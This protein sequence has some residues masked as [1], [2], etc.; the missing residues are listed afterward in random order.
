MST[1]TQMYRE[2]PF[3]RFSPWE[4]RA[5]LPDGAFLGQVLE[6][7]TMDN[8]AY[9]VMRNGST[10]IGDEPTIMEMR[11]TEVTD[12]PISGNSNIELPYDEGSDF[13]QIRSDSG[14]FTENQFTNGLLYKAAGDSHTFGQ[15]SLVIYNKPSTPF[16]SS[17]N[18]E[19]S[20]NIDPPLLSDWVGDPSG[21][22]VMHPLNG[23]TA[24]TRRHG[25]VCG[26]TVCAVPA[27][28]YFLGL[29]RGS[30][31]LET[32]DITQPI[33]A[34]TKSHRTAGRVRKA[35]A[36]E[37]VIAHYEG[38]STAEN[39]DAGNYSPFYINLLEGL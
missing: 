35:D 29:V 22:L 30:V 31:Y 11:Y 24:A 17:F 16:E 34:V 8:A 9:R 15:L 19:T 27:E 14:P 3:H 6:T 26:V 12:D 36:G 5:E 10:A 23:V 38:S 25:I 7:D 32:E 37:Q 33:G 4:P 39:L 2:V 1:D 13:L 18:Y 28:F 21:N 20:F